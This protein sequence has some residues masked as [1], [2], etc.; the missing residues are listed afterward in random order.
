MR[1][2]CNASTPS[3]ACVHADRAPLPATRCG[4]APTSSFLS[5]RP[6]CLAALCGESQLLLPPGGSRGGAVAKRPSTRLT[7][8]AK[9]QAPGSAPRPSSR[10]TARKA[11]VASS[12]RRWSGPR[13]SRTC[14]ASSVRMKSHARAVVPVCPLHSGAYRAPLRPRRLIKLIR[15]LKAETCIPRLCV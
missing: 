1:C 10:T 15:R 5:G 8:S 9:P 3:R 4:A 6:V 2:A 12:I 7:P 11:Q 14:D 13:N